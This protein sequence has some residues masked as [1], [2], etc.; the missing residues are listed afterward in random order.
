NGHMPEFV[1]EK[2]QNALNDASKAVRGSHIHVLGVAYKR[3]IDDVRGPPAIDIILLLQQR[4]ARITFS[5]PYVSKIEIGGQTL[6]SED[7]I[8]SS[9]AA[10]C[11][12]V[13]PDHR[14][15]DYPRIA[16]QR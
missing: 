12:V 16:H 3:D 4:G 15:V 6:N 13:V 14:G 9:S 2:V 1:V 10:D 8:A 11:V 7:A 5:D